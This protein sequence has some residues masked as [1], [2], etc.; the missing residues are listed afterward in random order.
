M[1]NSIKS[2]LFLWFLLVFSGFAIGFGLYLYEHQKSVSLSTVDGFLQTKSQFF[3]GL[4]EIYEDGKIHFELMEKKAGVERGIGL[5]DIP[6]SG[7]YYQIFSEDGILLAISPSLK[8]H[9][10][11]ISV[12]KA[13][14]EGKYFETITGPEGKPLRLL[15]YK[16]TI[17]VYQMEEQSHV[18]IIQ[19]AETL[20]E[21]YSF[22]TSLKRIMLYS[23]PT[24]ILLSG[25][26]GLLIAWLSLRPLKEFSQEVGK[27]SEKSMDKRIHEKRVS[28]ELR[29]LARTFNTTMDHLEKSFE[30][31]K[32]LISDASHELR[33]PTSI[34]KS[35]CE[36]P[37][38]KERTPREYINTLKVILDN[39][40]RME[41][42]IEGLL[43]ISSIEQKKTPFNKE[44]LPVNP[45]LN[46]VASMMKPIAEQREVEIKL[47]ALPQKDTYIMGSK[48]HLMELLMNIVDNAVRYNN[49][50]GKVIIG[51]E[52]N[53]DTI[54][55]KISDTGMGIPMNERKKIFQRFY[56]SDPSRSRYT[57]RSALNRKGTGLG[58]SIAKEIAKAHQGRIEVESTIEEGSTFII[59]LP[60]LTDQSA[61]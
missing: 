40:N 35:Y 7:H 39:T 47:N 2:R 52:N 8:K 3:A 10:L 42:L 15:T 28:K 59:S 43:T 21:V 55:I 34:I 48:D 9:L 50:G 14:E 17:T 30:E 33:S 37:L 44:R 38:R 36:I 22:I 20:E 27:I 31:Q 16:V 13:L 5:Y 41:G 23:I 57:G 26:G 24:T 18:F 11:P 54:V 29:E 56:R 61:V 4:I 49:K 53:T 51:L 6:L 32:R 1:L 60:K 58:L 46:K 12:E 19:T 25:L 45:L